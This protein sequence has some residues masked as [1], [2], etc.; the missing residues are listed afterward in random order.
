LSSSGN[1]AFHQTLPAALNRL[2]IDPSAIAQ[3]EASVVYHMIVEGV[4]AETGYHG[5]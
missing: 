5:F 4:L 2:L 3:V 1:A